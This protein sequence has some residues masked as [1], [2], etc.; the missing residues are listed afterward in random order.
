MKDYKLSNLMCQCNAFIIPQSYP[1]VDIA[2]KVNGLG[3]AIGH[4][5]YG[6][7]GFREIIALLF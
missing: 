1:S 6:G 5:G 4:Y 3:G 7:M 2:L